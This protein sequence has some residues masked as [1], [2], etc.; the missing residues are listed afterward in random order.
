MS[1]TELAILVAQ[2]Q[3]ELPYKFSAFER[4]ARHQFGPIHAL[5][6]GIVHDYDLANGIAQ[7]SLLRIMHALPQLSSVDKYSAWSRKITLNRARSWLAKEKQEQRKRDEFAQESESESQESKSLISFA[8]MVAILSLDERTIVAQK[9]MGDL[10]FSEIAE[11]TGYGVSA[12][13]MRY[14]RALEKIRSVGKY[15]SKFS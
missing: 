8:D 5:A 7:D 14:Y 2:T 6:Y 4:L 13:K 1:Q 9:I 3:Q 15:E 10:E 11:I 12:T